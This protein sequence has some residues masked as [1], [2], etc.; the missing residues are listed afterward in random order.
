MRNKVV[1][2][3][4]GHKYIRNQI[5]SNQSFYGSIL[6]PNRCPITATT[7]Q[8]TSGADSNS[9]DVDTPNRRR[10]R[11]STRRCMS[12]R[13]RAEA[14][15]IR[16]AFCTTQHGVVNNREQ[17]HSSP[18]FPLRENSP[19]LVWAQSPLKSNRPR[20]LIRLPV[21]FALRAFH[22]PPRPPHPTPRRVSRTSP[23][24][25]TACRT[26]ADRNGCESAIFGLTDHPVGM[27]LW[28]LRWLSPS[29]Q[30][31]ALWL[32]QITRNNTKRW[33]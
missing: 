29:I 21:A 15:P 3:W 11:E 24:L 17:S 23:T 33:L 4:V 28:N 2:S 26:T 5:R 10:T 12:R 32:V 14:Q 6:P 7:A 9:T 20:D 31:E 8:R 27:F 16:T 19:N 30:K 13:T 1:S 18:F 22:T 25:S